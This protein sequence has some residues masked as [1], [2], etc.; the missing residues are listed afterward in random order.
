MGHTMSS[1]Y[2]IDTSH[3]IL[4]IVEF[5]QKI[6]KTHPNPIPQQLNKNAHVLFLNH[7][8]HVILKCLHQKCH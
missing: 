6:R 3:T 8:I 7:L 5:S 1:L 4:I 2:D